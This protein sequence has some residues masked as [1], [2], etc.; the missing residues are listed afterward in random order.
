MDWITRRARTT[1]AG[2]RR[3]VLPAVVALAAVAVAIVP[4]T[5]AAKRID[6]TGSADVVRGTKKG[7]K[8]KVKGGDDKVAARGGRDR[9]SGGDG[10]D[11]LKGAKGKDRLK[12][13]DDNDRARGGK[14]KDRLKGNSGRDRLL[15]GSG[16]DK[17]SAVDEAKDRLVDGGAGANRCKID[18]EDLPVAVNCGELKVVGDG[19]GDGS[20]NGG[21]GGEEDDGLVLTDASGLTCSES[22]LLCQFSLEGTGADEP[23]G[24]VT[25]T[26]GVTLGGGP[27]VS[28]QGNGDWEALGAY[29]CSSDGGLRVT[30][31]SKSV[32][33][34]VTCIED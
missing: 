34:P 23:I 30:I 33:V 21:S 12:G 22:A 4:S 26:G 6:G 1:G 3:V 32:D 14:G 17:L 19:D 7:D 29:Q 16:G 10:R 11:Y 15:G 9:V 18:D 5:V 13:G 2:S 20:D 24:T 8:I 28:V 31:G 27:G 25:G